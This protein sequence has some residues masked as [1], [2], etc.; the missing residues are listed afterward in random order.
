MVRLHQCGH[1]SAFEC[2]LGV[3]DAISGVGAV[4]ERTSER[5]KS[6]VMLARQAWLA[7]RRGV[8]EAKGVHVAMPVNKPAVG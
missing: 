7:A 3:S 8:D 5:C 4:H 2:D 6:A 1:I